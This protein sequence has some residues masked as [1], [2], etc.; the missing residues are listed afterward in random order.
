MDAWNENDLYMTEEEFASMTEEEFTDW[1][2]KFME[3]G[4]RAEEDGVLP[5]SE[6]TMDTI[7][8]GYRDKTFQDYVRAVP[9][10]NGLERIFSD[11]EDVERVNRAWETARLC[12]GKTDSPQKDAAF[13]SLYAALYSYIRRVNPLWE[14][15]AER[16]ALWK[17]LQD[18]YRTVYSL[19]GGNSEAFAGLCATD[20]FERFDEEAVCALGAVRRVNGKTHAAGVLV[21]EM[22]PP[23]DRFDEPKA[24]LQW[25]YVAEEYRSM[26]VADDLMAGFYH[27]LNQAGIRAMTCKLPAMGLLSIMLSDFLSSWSVFFSLEPVEEFSKTLGEISKCRELKKWSDENGI[28]DLKHMGMA[29]FQKAV[30]GIMADCGEHDFKLKQKEKL[31]PG[32]SLVYRENGRNLAFL[33][34]DLEISG[35]LSIRELQ[36]NPLTEEVF[37]QLIGVCCQRAK[38]LFAGDTVCVAKPEREFTLQMLDRLFPEHGVPVYLVGVNI[39]AEVET[40]GETF[41]WMRELY[42]NGK[43]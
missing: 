6:P 8:A 4:K 16:L 2:S 38:K 20:L 41:A 40:D 31:H 10:G 21:F 28:T 18:E 36:G 30:E 9:M 37:L 25:L 5:A 12:F 42:Q 43:I 35:T 19:D 17:E 22:I 23:E 32:L 27:A 13:L 34:V 14:V 33:L 39:S 26:H 29:G 3:A 11:E 1:F 24:V 7:Y 15:G